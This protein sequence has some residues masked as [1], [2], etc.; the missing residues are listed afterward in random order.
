MCNDSLV[1]L[2]KVFSNEHGTSCPILKNITTDSANFTQRI[3]FEDN[4]DRRDR[5]NCGC[6]FNCNCNGFEMNDNMTFSINS[7]QVIINDFN[8]ANPGGLTENNVT[9][10]GLP[11]DNIDSFNQR[12]MAST[13]D[14]MSQ[15]V[16]CSCIEKGLPTPVFFMV[17][18]AGPWLV[19]V[20]FV[21]EG[22]I[23]DCG[24]CR[25][26]KLCISSKENS[27]IAIPSQSTFS[28]PCISLPC[29]TDGI[30]PVINFQ[31]NAV[32]SLL[33]PE[34]SVVPGETC[35]LRLT[36]TLVLEPTIN[37]EVTR[38]T[39]FRTKAEEIM[40][41]CDELSL[42]MNCDRDFGCRDPR[43]DECPKC[44][45][46]NNPNKIICCQYNGMNGMSW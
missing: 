28:I 14:L 40:Q 24:T 33:S 23:Y 10:N 41:P 44:H 45:E 31:F 35:Q 6:V 18:G 2:S 32:G 37:V 27:P 30:A 26:F 38:E 22:T 15:I 12:Y 46:D 34:L 21:I 20:T 8:L 11:V 42:C 9:V 7:T 25:N 1:Y 43:R 39:L 19:R 36:T 13:Y 17:T 4:D 29:T 3:T 16:K 5:C